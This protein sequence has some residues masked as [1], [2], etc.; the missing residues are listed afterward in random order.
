[1]SI[2][3][4]RALGDTPNNLIPSRAPERTG[5]VNVTTDTAMRASAVWAAVRLRAD[6][7]STS[8]G[9]GVPECER[10]GRRS[11]DPSGVGEPGR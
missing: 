1:M 10:H 11:S 3:A 8:A 5:S 6:L 7:L 9:E 4:R 2:L